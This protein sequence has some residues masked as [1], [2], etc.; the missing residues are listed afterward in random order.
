MSDEIDDRWQSPLLCSAP[1]HPGTR[2]IAD[3]LVLGSALEHLRVT[4]GGYALL[5]HWKQ[6]EFHH[7]NL[8]R[9]QNA[10]GLPGDVLIISTNC[11]GGVKEVLCFATPPERSAL[12]HARCPESPEFS[13]KIPPLLARDATLHDFNPCVLLRLDARSELKPENRVRMEGGGW[14]MTPTACSVPEQK[15]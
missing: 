4:H 3:Q 1:S 12:W 6:G 8:I 5:A 9:V 13:G 11:N 14:Q 15:P 10:A 7:D 2:A